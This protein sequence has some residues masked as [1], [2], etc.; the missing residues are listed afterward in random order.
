MVDMYKKNLQKHEPY[1]QTNNKRPG[2]PLEQSENEKG[3]LIQ[4]RNYAWEKGK[5]NL[6]T[7]RLNL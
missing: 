7:S 6:T 4:R 1:L 5:F 3:E 2:P